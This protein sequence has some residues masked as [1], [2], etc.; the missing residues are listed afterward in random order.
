VVETQYAPVG[1]RVVFEND[2]V[3][4]WEVALEPGESLPMHLH[5]LDY[6]FVVVSGGRTTITWEDG[7]SETNEHQPGAVMWR[8]AP[9]AHA[10]RNDGQ[11]R[12]VNCLVELK[13]GA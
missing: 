9:H 1:T 6:V 12:Y 7:R 13:T 10:L 4:V 3:R 8:Q 11:T 2:R 5:E